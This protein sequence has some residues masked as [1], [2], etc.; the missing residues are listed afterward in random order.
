MTDNDLRKQAIYDDIKRMTH[1]DIKRLISAVELVLQAQLKTLVKSY[2]G[3]NYE[4]LLDILAFC[5]RNN[6]PVPDEIKTRLLDAL[7]TWREGRVLSLDEAF[8]V[9]LPK[10]KHEAPFLRK[11]RFSDDVYDYIHNMHKEYGRSIDEG[12]FQQVADIFRLSS[13]SVAR[14]LYYE[15]EYER[16]KLEKHLIAS[17]HEQLTGE[18]LPIETQNKLD[19]PKKKGRKRSSKFRTP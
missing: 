2:E 3:G 8:N 16:L 14:D 9:A 10:G 4:A 5:L 6:E 7:D 18:A 11:K 17:I 15:A 12:L 1:D 13:A 19:A